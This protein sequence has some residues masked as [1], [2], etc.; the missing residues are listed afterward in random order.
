MDLIQVNVYTTNRCNRNCPDCYVTK[1]DVEMSR[2]TAKNVGNWISDL[3]H[4]E[5]IKST[6]IHFLG[7]EPLL[8]LPAIVSIVDIFNKNK[9]S[10]N[11][12][13]GIKGSEGFVVFTNGDFLNQE[14]MR[15]LKDR[16]IMVKL[17][18]TNLRLYDINQRVQKIKDVFGGAGLAVVLDDLNMKRLPELA[19]LSVQNRIHMRLNRLYNGGTIPGY[20]EQYRKQMHK[21]F[22]ILL[23]S[24]WAMWPNFLIENTYVTW[25]GPQNP[26]ACGRFLFIIEPDGTIRACNADIDTR[27]GHIDTHKKMLDFTFPCRWSATN[28]PECCGCEWRVWCQGGCPYTRKLVF[29][30][31]EKRTPFCYAFKELFP[32]VI[33]L[34]EKYRC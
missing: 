15:T 25:E 7:G 29:G 6:M 24:D 12:P 32:R 4:K 20:V 13:F 31:Y 18:P 17:N 33:E 8:N 28:L 21:M 14:N 23:A 22:D 10:F 9:P 1:D 2:E 26:N 27:M 3:C 30:T 16:R 19:L 11:R 5:K 34:K